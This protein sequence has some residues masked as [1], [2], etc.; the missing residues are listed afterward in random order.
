LLVEPVELP[1]VVPD[2]LDS[3]DVPLAGSL[4][5]GLLSVEVGSVLVVALEP[6]GLLPL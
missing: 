3:V 4:A 6:P 2:E 1:E 5:A